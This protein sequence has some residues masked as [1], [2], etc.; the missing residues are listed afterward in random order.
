MSNPNNNLANFLM[1]KLADGSTSADAVRKH[2]SVDPSAFYGSMWRFTNDQNAPPS[3][4]RKGGPVQVKT[5][6]Q[7]KTAIGGTVQKGELVDQAKA[8][9]EPV[10]TPDTFSIP[11]YEGRFAEADLKAMKKDELQEIAAGCGVSNLEQ[12]KD[13]LIEAIMNSSPSNVEQVS[14]QQG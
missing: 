8:M 3:G 6:A 11:N 10:M 13:K 7:S 1:F 4:L 9:G 5:A 2:S 14:D 12:T